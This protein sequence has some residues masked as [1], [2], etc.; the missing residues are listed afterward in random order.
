MFCIHFVVHYPMSKRKGL[1]GRDSESS[2]ILVVTILGGDNT[3]YDDVSL[4]SVSSRTIL[5]DG[6]E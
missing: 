1:K 2:F 4:N 5:I 6:H 3:E